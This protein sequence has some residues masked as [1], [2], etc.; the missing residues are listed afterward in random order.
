MVPACIVRVAPLFTNRFPIS[1][2]GPSVW[3]QVVST[4]IMPLRLMPEVCARTD[5]KMQKI[6]MKA[7]KK[8]VRNLLDVD[9][10]IH[11]PFMGETNGLLMGCR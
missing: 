11:S 3:V 10:L 8:V 7:M 5:C 4:A 1:V 6:K 2:Y 9:L